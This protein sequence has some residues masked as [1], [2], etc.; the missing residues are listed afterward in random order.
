M[1]GKGIGSRRPAASL[2]SA[3]SKRHKSDPPTSLDADD[4]VEEVGVVY[5]M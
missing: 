4:I 1:E 2:T 5:N 3:P